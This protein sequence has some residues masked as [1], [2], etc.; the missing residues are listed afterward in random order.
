MA[1]ATV[2]DDEGDTVATDR[3]DPMTLGLTHFLSSGCPVG[4]ASPEVES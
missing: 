2:S 3:V 4:K 1:P